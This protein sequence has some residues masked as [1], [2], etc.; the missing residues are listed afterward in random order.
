MFFNGFPTKGVCPADCAGHHAAGFNFVLPH[1][2]AETATAQ[3]DWRF[4]RKCQAMFF[5]GFPTKGVCKAGGGHEAAGFNFVLPHAPAITLRAV[6]VGARFI[7]V[8]GGGFTPNKAVKIGYDITSGGAPTTH[9][10]G[11]DADTADGNWNFIHR[12]R[13]NLGGEISGALVQAT[14]VASNTVATASI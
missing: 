4:C 5:N 10:K 13:V 2:V 14:D 3:Q 12:I 9:Q 1:V 8:T 6:A 11:E 7:E